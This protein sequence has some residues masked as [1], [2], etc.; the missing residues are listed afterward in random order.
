[1]VLIKRLTILLLVVAFISGCAMG[2]QA[3]DDNDR[4]AQVQNVDNNRG[5][6]NNQTRM[7][8]A[9]KAQ[10]KITDMDEVRRA[11][12]IVA[13]RN[14]Y[15]AIVQDDE[16][17]GDVRRDLEQK[18]SDQVKETDNN[19]RNVFVSSNPDFVNRMNDYGSKIEGGQPIQGLFEEFTEMVQRVFPN[20]R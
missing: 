17:K 3:R 18:I 11:T 12:V 13:N 14:A 4:G 16:S 9:D 20:A 10:D 19:I 15:V 8:V 2:N 7:E 5:G 1:M 6:E